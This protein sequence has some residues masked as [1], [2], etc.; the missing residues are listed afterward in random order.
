MNKIFKKLNIIFHPFILF[1]KIRW[2]FISKSLK[3]CGKK[4]SMGCRFKV[5]E[6][7]N[8]LLGNN[9]Y[10]GHDCVLACYEMH[11]D[12][13]TGYK[14][15][16]K[17]EDNINFGN[18]CHISCLDKIEIKSGVLTG[19]NVSI[20]D[21]FHGRLTKDESTVRPAMRDLYSKGPIS[22]GKNVWIGK[23]VC[24]MPNVTIGDYSVIGANSVVTHD[25]PPYTIAV[26]TPA[27][28]IRNIQ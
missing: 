18:Y 24:I 3:G 4:T 20:I 10:F 15:V 7:Q 13:K 17:I 6:P 25:I 14:P 23:N 1:E 2:V 21:N 28:V 5:I 9:T 26:G 8:I 16:L 19:D 27:K 12:K 11:N 22:I